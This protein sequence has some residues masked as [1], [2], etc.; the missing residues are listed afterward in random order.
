MWH[1]KYAGVP[2]QTGQQQT[3]LQ[4]L[5]HNLGVVR[6]DRLPA[7]ICN[8]SSLSR[9]L[10][11]QIRTG[12]Q[13]FRMFVR[14]PVGGTTQRHHNWAINVAAEAILG[15]YCEGVTREVHPPRSSACTRL[16]AGVTSHSANTQTKQCRVHSDQRPIEMPGRPGTLSL[17]PVGTPSHCTYSHWSNT[18]TDFNT[19]TVPILQSL[20]PTVP[21]QYRQNVCTVQWLF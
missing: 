12:F 20:F 10:S 11:V 9:S 15:T 4:V 3:F 6:A 13:Q 2:E 17:S 19:V 21:I 5:P 1:C 16:R 18:V 14:R 7:G 8:N